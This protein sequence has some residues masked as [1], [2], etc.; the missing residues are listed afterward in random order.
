MLNNQEAPEDFI[1]ATSVT[2]SVK[3]FAERAFKEAGFTR[4][5]WSGEGSEETLVDLTSDKVLL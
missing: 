5:K 3:D 4:L 2:V 1:V